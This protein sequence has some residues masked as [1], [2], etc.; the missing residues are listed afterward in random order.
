MTPSLDAYRQLADVYAGIDRYYSA[1]IAK[2]GA[3]PLGVDWSCVPTQELRF[4]QLLKI[5]D[6][7]APAF[8]LNDVGCGYG[9][10]LSFFAKYRHGTDLD[11]LGIDVS[12]AM[13]RQARRLWRRTNSARF[14][15][16]CA[17]PRLA[18]Y[19]VASGIFNVKLDQP[20][21]LWERFIA[22]TLDQMRATSRFGFAANFMS[23]VPPGVA[24]TSNLYRTPPEPWVR[25]CRSH[26]ASVEVVAGYGMR[27]F[28]LLVR[29]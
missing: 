18:D 10:L 2:Y 5:C 19:S 24:S 1:K 9:A 28:T 14:T 20:L 23:P 16:A 11:Y 12:E 17:S 22:A 8:S 4:L 13:V 27:E 26:A 3:N 7:S 21:D 29:T 6:F 15:V 25:H